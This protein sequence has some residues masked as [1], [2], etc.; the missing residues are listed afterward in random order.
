MEGRDPSQGTNKVEGEPAGVLTRAQKLKKELD[1]QKQRIDQ[2]MEQNMR[3]L[4]AIA[5]Q[6]GVGPSSPATG[7]NARKRDRGFLKCRCEKLFGDK[8]RLVT[9]LIKP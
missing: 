8:Y 4:E 1:L 3:Q 2:T 5:K 6:A 9:I 7:S